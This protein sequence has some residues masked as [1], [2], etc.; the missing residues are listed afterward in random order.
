MPYTFEYSKEFRD[1]IVC[2]HRGKE[3]LPFYDG[4]ITAHLGGPNS[5]L[6]TF[7]IYLFPEI[8]Y[9]CGD[10]RTKKVL[11]FGCGTGSTTAV[12]AM[13]CKRVVAYDIDKK[14]IYIAEKRLKEHNLGDRVEFVSAPNIEEVLPQIGNFDFILINGVIEH[15]PLSKIGLRKRILGSLF[16]SLNINGCLYINDTPN[17]LWPIDFHTTQL[18]WIPWRSPGSKIAYEKA[19][20]MGRH[21]DNSGSH[22]DGPLGLEERGAWGATFF[23]IT[24]YLS[25]MP[26]EVLNLTPGHNKHVSYGISASS[27][28]YRIYEQVLYYILVKGFNIPLTAFEKYLTNLIIRKVG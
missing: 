25:D 3:H 1:L 22:S 27:A 15:I 20:N 26:Y 16:N 24:S 28:K 18:W 21:S 12:L 23:E 2:L 13:N 9:H 4:Y 19:V 11:D 10:L 8:R 7:S 17:R 5:R 6:N 14:S